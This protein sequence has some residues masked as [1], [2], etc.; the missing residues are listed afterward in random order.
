M[1]GIKVTHIIPNDP[2]RAMKAIVMNI[3]LTGLKNRISDD[4]KAIAVS[5]SAKENVIKRLDK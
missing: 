5:S 3:L 2:T 4:V 1:H